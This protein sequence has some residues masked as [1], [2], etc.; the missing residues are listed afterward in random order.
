MPPMRRNLAAYL[1]EFFGTAIMLFIASR[2][3]RSI[4]DTTVW[5]SDVSNQSYRGTIA[6]HF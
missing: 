2:D 1:A 3:V 5:R 6:F 4:A